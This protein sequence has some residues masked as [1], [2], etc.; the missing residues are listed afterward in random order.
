M[1]IEPDYW[2]TITPGFENAVWGDTPGCFGDKTEMAK[3]LKLNPR[4]T[5]VSVWSAAPTPEAQGAAPMEPTDL[6]TIAAFVESVADMKQANPA[7]FDHSILWEHINGVRVILNNMRAAPVPAP[8]P[9]WTREKP[10]EEGDYW[11]W[12]KG[13][14]AAMFE[15]VIGDERG[16]YIHGEERDEM[17][18]AISPDAYW[19]KVDR[20]PIPSPLNPSETGKV[21]EA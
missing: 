15:Q 1:S 7:F 21:G 13:W 9:T 14:R 16:L 17:I 2:I 4:A 19:L 18:N 10:T 12:E 11:R 5:A 3:F 8:A 20:P 6:D